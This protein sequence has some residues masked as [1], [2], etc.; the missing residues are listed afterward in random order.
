MKVSSL[1]TR[2]RG[3]RSRAQYI[4]YLFFKFFFHCI[5]RREAS[6]QFK[7]VPL[8]SRQMPSDIMFTANTT[9]TSINLEQEMTVSRQLA[10]IRRAEVSCCKLRWL[11]QTLNFELGLLYSSFSLLL[12]S[13]LIRLL[14]RI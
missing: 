10:L 1:M 9:T 13:K 3:K 5:C 14:S 2:R 12:N 6:L 8:Y 4:F 11:I 7:F